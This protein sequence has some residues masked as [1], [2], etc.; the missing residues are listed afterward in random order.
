MVGEIFDLQPIHIKLTDEFTNLSSDFKNRLKIE[1]RQTYWIYHFD[2]LKI[3]E[4]L[5][6][7][8]YTRM[9]RKKRKSRPSYFGRK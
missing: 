2:F 3:F 1:Y 6:K 5:S 8:L 9:N 4:R 7:T